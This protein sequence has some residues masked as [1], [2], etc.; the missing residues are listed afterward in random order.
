VSGLWQRAVLVVVMTLVGGALMTYSIGPIPPV[1]AARSRVRA[2][3]G[4]VG[5]LLFVCGL[6]LWWLKFALTVLRDGE[7]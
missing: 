4:W 1:S 6:L 3:C 5:W 7:R 2:V